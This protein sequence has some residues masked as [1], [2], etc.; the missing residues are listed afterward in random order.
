VLTGPAP[1]GIDRNRLE[2]PSRSPQRAVEYPRGPFTGLCVRKNL[3][4]QAPDQHTLLHTSQACQPHRQVRFLPLAG[5]HRPG[6]QEADRG[7]RYG[8]LWAASEP[9]E[10]ASYVFSKTATWL[11]LVDVNRVR[12]Q[13]A[14]R[15][16][17]LSPATWPMSASSDGQM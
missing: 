6:V 11:A 10:S 3:P 7:R 13:F 5:A 16:R 9:S 2:R 17:N 1:S 8:A 14:Q 4:A 15:S 12:S